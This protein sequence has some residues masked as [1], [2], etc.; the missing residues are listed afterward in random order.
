MQTIKSMTIT[1][2]R[3]FQKSYGN[4]YHTAEIVLEKQDDTRLHLKS[5]ILYGYGEQYLQ[6]AFNLLVANGFYLADEFF[7]FKDEW[8][9]WKGTPAQRKA[10]VNCYDVARKRELNA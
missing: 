5:P 4:T 6:T 9:Y 1:G 2:K 3:W 10:S 7:T 8:L